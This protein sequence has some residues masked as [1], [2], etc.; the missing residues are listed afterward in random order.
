MGLPKKVKPESDLTVRSTSQLTGKPGLQGH[1]KSHYG[2]QSGPKLRNFTGQTTEL[3]YKYIAG[4]K[5]EELI[6][7]R[8]RTHE[9]NAM[10]GGLFVD[11]GLALKKKTTTWYKC[12]Q[13]K[14]KH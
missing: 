14:K 2:V 6:H 9:Q 4:K 5:E 12:V 7:E 11:P 1:F 13:L 8:K 10:C 3:I